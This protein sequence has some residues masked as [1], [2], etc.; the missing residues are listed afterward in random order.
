MNM[1]SSQYSSP[2]PTIAV[3]KTISICADILTFIVIY[4]DLKGKV[5]SRND[6]DV[7]D[8]V[9]CLI[10]CV[11]IPC[12][13]NKSTLFERSQMRK[14]IVKALL[15]LSA[16]NDTKQYFVR[17]TN[18]VCVL[19]AI[20]TSFKSE[21]ELTREM[22]LITLN[23]ITAPINQERSHINAIKDIIAHGGIDIL[24]TLTTNA[25]ESPII[26]HRSSSLLSRFFLSPPSQTK[27]DEKTRI[28]IRNEFLNLTS[29]PIWTLVSDSITAESVARTASHL[30]SVFIVS[31][32]Q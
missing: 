14:M 10:S 29:H 11:Q 24:T 8:I 26:K 7:E 16:I 6:H 21:F 25:S 12:G 28:K 32:S 13:T 9:K 31:A 22:A 30:L 20:S 5:R 18:T 3:F 19:L 15:A 23:N 4:N 2:Q 17:D 1:V 27:L